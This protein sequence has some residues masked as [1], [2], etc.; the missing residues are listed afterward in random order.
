MV[1]RSLHEDRE[2]KGID[3]LKFS[4]TMVQLSWMDEAE[5]CK[6][7]TTVLAESQWRRWDIMTL[8]M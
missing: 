5:A 7:Q 6:E 4:I 2:C 8:K 3:R 1:D